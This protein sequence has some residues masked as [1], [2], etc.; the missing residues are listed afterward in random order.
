M[1]L[2]QPHKQRALCVSTER[3]TTEKCDGLSGVTVYLEEFG[4]S[5][6]EWCVSVLLSLEK[7][8][9]FLCV[10]VRSL[11]YISF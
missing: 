7:S 6:V 8:S 5:G 11:S 3:S 4:Q 1:V 10:P 2:T 9:S